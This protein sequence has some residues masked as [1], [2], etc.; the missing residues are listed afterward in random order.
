[1]YNIDGF[2]FEDEVMAE[3]A[4]KEEEGV[5][6]I[7]EN[8]TLQDVESVYQLYTKLLRQELFITPI[9]LRFLTELQ[10]ILYRSPEIPNHEIPSIK[11]RTQNP[12][13]EKERQE[14]KITEEELAKTQES[15]KPSEPAKA[16]EVK[17]ETKAEK[18]YKHAYH[19]ALFFAIVFGLSVIGM[20]LIAELSENNV[21]ILN[22]REQ[23]ENEYSE[24]EAELKA[25][26]SQLK[27]WEKELEDREAASKAE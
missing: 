19:V 11:V 13:D 20:F 24:W 9:G 16:E 25:K 14:E 21:N 7:K 5:R 15:V 17:N 2:I 8:A 3:L 23:I 18:K 22:Y 10:R 27:E 6:Y 4:K 26:E 12:L 1:M